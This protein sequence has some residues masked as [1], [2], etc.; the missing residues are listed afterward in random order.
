MVNVM[1]EFMIPTKVGIEKI[2]D[3]IKKYLSSETHDHNSIAFI[4][5]YKDTRKFL[6]VFLRKYDVKLMDIE[7][8]EDELS[9]Y[10]DEYLITISEF[11][12][13][14]SIYCELFKTKNEYKLSDSDVYFVMEDCN[15][16]LLSKLSCSD[17]FIFICEYEDE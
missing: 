15:C 1:R 5:K 4:G 9:G 14:I 6:S 17:E 13:E 12:K 10:K 11:D 8:Y 2:V 7:L 16:K 3:T